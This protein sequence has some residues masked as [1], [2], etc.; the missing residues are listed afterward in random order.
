[1]S[2][3]AAT[4][5]SKGAHASPHGWKTSGR[6]ILFLVLVAAIGVIF[7]LTVATGSVNIPLDD[8]AAVLLGN[9]ASKRTWTTIL[10]DIRLPKAITALLAGSALAVSGLLMQTLFRNPLAG[11]SVLGIDAGA[12][13]GVAIVVL[14]AGSDSQAASSFAGTLG[15]VGAAGLGASVVVFAVLLVAERVRNNVTLLILGLMF[16][17]V[18]TAT[19]TVLMQYSGAERVQAYLIWTFASFSGVSW[20]HLRI[21]APAVAF[22]L[23]IAVAVTKPLNALLL[24]ESYAR[25]L[26]VRVLRLRVQVVVSSSLLVGAV[27]AFCGPI[28]FLGIAVPHLARGLFRTADHRTLIPA[29]LL[30]GGLLAM[31]ADLLTRLPGRQET[32]PLNAILSLVGAPIVA[33]IVVTQKHAHA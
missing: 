10:W 2:A 32:L 18:A 4:K 15:R 22:G 26:G 1:M 13:L 5:G 8:V 21:L 23:A 31:L 17:Y 30:I 28:L 33:W 7:L 12:S 19:V 27:T 16:G 11:P 25:S 24:G 6:A 14:L 20:P 29:V 3:S 9:E